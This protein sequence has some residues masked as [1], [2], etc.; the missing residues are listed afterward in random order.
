MP[1]SENIQSNNYT[2]LKIIRSSISPLSAMIGISSYYGQVIGNPILG[3]I[4][5]L[6]F[7]KIRFRYLKF[8]SKTK[9]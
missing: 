2:L 8:K 1:I 3:S 4:N 9:Y 6:L 7:G 5:S